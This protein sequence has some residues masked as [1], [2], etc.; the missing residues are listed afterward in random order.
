MARNYN[1]RLPTVHPRVRGEHATACFWGLPAAGSSPR[2]RGTPSRCGPKEDR[3]R[4]IPACAGN[5]FAVRTEEDRHRFIPACAGN[6]P[7]GRKV[8]AYATVHP[9]VRGEHIPKHIAERKAAGSSP[10]AR[11]TPSPPSLLPPSPSPVHPRVRGEHLARSAFR[12][13]ARGSSPRARGTLP[14]WLLKAAVARFIPAC[15]GNTRDRRTPIVSPLVRPRV[16][17]EHIRSSAYGAPARGSSPRARGTPPYPW[18]SVVVAGSSPRARGTRQSLPVETRGAG[19]SPLRG[20]TERSAHEP[21]PK[22]FIPA[23]AG[24]TDAVPAPVRDCA[25]HPRVRGEH[26]LKH[27]FLVD[28]DGSSPRARGTHARS[29]QATSPLRFIPACA[30]NTVAPSPGSE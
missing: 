16:R 9:R 25:V 27:C 17:G 4:F 7:A 23:C 2:A 20:N 19:S 18:R 11:G 30:G 28:A 10:R 13:P 24:N 12:V 3:H 22:R 8:A 29:G 1:R 26:V 15:A 5:T 21:I 14:D 6:T